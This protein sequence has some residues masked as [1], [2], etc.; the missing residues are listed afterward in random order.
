[1]A[2]Q[3]RRPLLTFYLSQ[4]PMTGDRGQDFRTL[5][6]AIDPGADALVDALIRDVRARQQ[7]VRSALDDDEAESLSFIGSKS[8]DHG[9]G[10]VSRDITRVI[11][12]DLPEFRRAR[13][14]EAAF[15]MLRDAAEGVGIFVLL[16]GNLGSHHTALEPE[17]FRGF[18]LADNVAP[19]VVIN[20]QDAKAAWSF[21]L[22][23]EIVHL[24]IGETGVSGGAP[25]VGV[26]RFCNDVASEMLLPERDI[27]RE[28]W[29][30]V[31]HDFRRLENEISIFARPRN[32]SY[33]LVAYRLFRARII[34]R[35][36]WER[37][38]RHFRDLWR[39]QRAS[40]RE[41]ARQDDSSGPSYYVVR[42]HKLGKALINFVR[43]QM[44]DGELSPTKAAKILGVKARSVGPLIRADQMAHEG[45][46]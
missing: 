46:Q 4:P 3:Y 8:L 1:M 41:Q 36:M 9:V 38:C 35:D 16:I 22:L 43:Q 44:N 31:A 21:T 23:H 34:D 15:A 32:L 20:D 33:S 42:R 18:A 37:C 7:M 25:N 19:F 14:P 28:H 10:D 17:I 12:F 13:T 29:V 40:A 27:A 26:E 5:P 39:R 45:R 30:G 11:G 6:G 2:K 24:W